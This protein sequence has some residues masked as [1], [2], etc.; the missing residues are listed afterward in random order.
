[1]SCYREKVVNLVEQKLGSLIEGIEINNS[2]API[3]RVKLSNLLSLAW[4]FKEDSELSFCTLLDITAVDWFKSQPRFQLWWQFL[5]LRNKH[6]VALTAFTD[7]S[8]PSL[9]SLYKS[10]NFLEREVFDM[11]GIRFEGHPDLR[12]ILMYEEFEGHPLRKDY[13]VR[14]K[15]P[16][17]PLRYPEVPNTSA[18]L[19][20][21][22]LSEE[23][24]IKI[25]KQ[26]LESQP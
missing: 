17:I 2:V 15:Q 12:R 10:A 11:F 9:V 13:P 3:V 24:L 18:D 1:M 4:A 14:G 20:R 25:K 6:R 22:P 8:A 23:A 21:P 26:K 5:S 7:E 16:R 19:S